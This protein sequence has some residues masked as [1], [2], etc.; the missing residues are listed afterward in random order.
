MNGNQVV[1]IHHR[2]ER[3]ERIR[4]RAETKLDLPKETLAQ[5]S[6]ANEE[7]KDTQDGTKEHWDGILD[8]SKNE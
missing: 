8:G 7:G 2:E 5:D 4:E 3:K 6:I 1:A